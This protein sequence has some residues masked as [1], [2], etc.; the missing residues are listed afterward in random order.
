MVSPTQP[1]YTITIQVDLSYHE[2]EKNQ[3]DLKLP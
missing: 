1:R 3:L 2:K